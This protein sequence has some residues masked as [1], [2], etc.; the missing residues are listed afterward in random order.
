MTNYEFKAEYDKLVDVYPE[1]F[2]SKHKEQAIANYVK[3]LDAKWWR[4]FV[5]Q[6]ILSSNPR[7]NIDEAARG[8]RLARQKY[9]STMELIQAQDAM[10]EKISESGLQD[11]LKSIGAKSLLEAIEIKKEGK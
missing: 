6:M 1:H 9:R 3:D 2:K 8:E 4:A 5:N 7:L 11:I 10:S